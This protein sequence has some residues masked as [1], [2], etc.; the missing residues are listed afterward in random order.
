MKKYCI[1][2]LLLLSSAIAFCNGHHS[3]RSSLNEI[4]VRFNPDKSEVL[5]FTSDRITKWEV[6][7]GKLIGSYD[8]YMSDLKRYPHRNAKLIDSDDHLSELVFKDGDGSI[9]RFSLLDRRY[10][11]FPKFNHSLMNFHGYVDGN[12]MVYSTTGYDVSVFDQSNG[13]D[14]VIHSKYH[15]WVLVPVYHKGVIIKD[16]EVFHF[17][18]GKTYQ[19]KKLG[20]KNRY[21]EVRIMP[22]DWVEAYSGNTNNRETVQFVNIKTGKKESYK[23]AEA[24]NQYYPKSVPQ[25]KTEYIRALVRSDETSYFQFYSQGSYVDG[26]V[27]YFNHGL[28]KYDIKTNEVLADIKFSDTQDNFL[29]YL[30]KTKAEEQV[31]FNEFKINL[32]QLP[33]NYTFDYNNA[34]AREIQDIPFVRFGM[35]P[36]AGQQEFGIGKIKDCSDGGI[37]V[38]TMGFTQNSSSQTSHFYIRQYNKDGI[39]IDSKDLGKTV[40]T[41]G[42]FQ[43]ITKFNIE[44]NN[45][46]YVA[47]AR[48]EF[49]KGTQQ[50]NYAGGC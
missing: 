48:W 33:Y 15:G 19:K 24:K 9:H 37:I 4:G 7:T 2:L 43:Q 46:G 27:T 45:T 38:L 23:G 35:H 25:P 20:I 40:R 28:R 42:S 1:T 30:N 50:K 49:P 8:T 3:W 47:T 21:S 10:I 11:N 5:I 18:D 34:S 32:N 17:V 44:Q 6:E 39:L 36:T 14:K 13:K 31:A 16:Q 12:K 41:G 22:D 26:K 29:A